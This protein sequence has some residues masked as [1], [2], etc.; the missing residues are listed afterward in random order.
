MTRLRLV[1]AALPLLFG[2]A[3][4]A[5]A[6]TLLDAEDSLQAA[7]FR[8][9]TVVWAVHNGVDSLEID[10]EPAS[11]TDEELMAESRAAAGVVWRTARLRFDQVVVDPDVWGRI[12]RDGDWPVFDRATLE[13]DFGPRPPGLDRTFSDYANPGHYLRW[14]V[15]GVV[16]FLASSV[17]IVVLVLRSS[18]RGRAAGA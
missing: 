16:A 6:D 5:M 17:V 1:L 4:C 8:D 13:R 18:R 10:W 14:A 15:G 7:G 2:L 11:Q 9:A 3:G 12:E